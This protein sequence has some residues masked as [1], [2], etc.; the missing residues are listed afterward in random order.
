MFGG[1]ARFVPE[2]EASVR[3]S[4]AELRAA[5]L[6]VYPQLRSA[7]VDYAWGG[8]LDFTYDSM[9]HLGQADGYYYALGYAGHGVALAS[10]LGTQLGCNAGHRRDASEPLRPIAFPRR[11]AWVV[12]GQGLVSGSGGGLV[13]ISGPGGVGRPQRPHRATDSERRDISNTTPHST[14]N[15]ASH[16]NPETISCPS[17]T[18]RI[19]ATTGLT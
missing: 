9:P 17:V 8:T 3:E 1:R 18:P 16:S 11:A 19:R 13:Q 14:M 10:L 4:A 2:T 5:M 7:R 15:T 12:S 6:N